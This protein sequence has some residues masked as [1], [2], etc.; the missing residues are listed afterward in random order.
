MKVGEFRTEEEQQL[1]QTHTLKTENQTLVQKGKSKREEIRDLQNSFK[2]GI[3]AQ[4]HNPGKKA[5]GGG[6]PSFR[7]QPGLWSNTFPPKE[8]ETQRK[9]GGQEEKKDKS[10]EEVQEEEE[11]VEKGERT[12]KT[13]TTTLKQT[14]ASDL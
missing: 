10:E 7:D 5:K 12:I 1:P 13:N 11:G 9:K 3:V 2:P 14:S 4:T 6:S 8:A